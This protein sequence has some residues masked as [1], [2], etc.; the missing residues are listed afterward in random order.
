MT[1]CSKAKDVAKLSLA[2]ILSGA[3][4]ERLSRKEPE[5]NMDTPR[6]KAS[7]EPLAFASKL[8]YAIRSATSISSPSVLQHST[9]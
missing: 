3:R 2:A 5:A 7:G 6:K 1:G 9:P 8:L 4:V